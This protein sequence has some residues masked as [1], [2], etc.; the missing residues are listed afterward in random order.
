MGALVQFPRFPLAADLSPVLKSRRWNLCKCESNTEQRNKRGKKSHIYHIHTVVLKSIFRLWIT[1]LSD[2]MPTKNPANNSCLAAADSSRCCD[3]CDSLMT[4]SSPAGDE[5]VRNLSTCPTASA[6]ADID[7]L[8]LII[9]SLTQ[10]LSEKKL[11]SEPR[12]KLTPENKLTHSFSL[13]LACAENVIYDSRLWKVSS[14]ERQPV[15]RGSFSPLLSVLLRSAH[16]NTYIW[17]QSSEGC[18]SVAPQMSV[19]ASS[20]Y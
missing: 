3:K 6:T 18:S 7:A 8:C 20:R 13:E 11:T 10:G 19:S 15:S 16:D 1:S 14:D 2:V 5:H 9:Y 17:D 12:W 4:G